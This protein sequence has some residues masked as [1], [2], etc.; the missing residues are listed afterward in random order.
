MAGARDA[1][2]CQAGHAVLRSPAMA[3]SLPAALEIPDS[4]TRAAGPLP[5]SR[6]RC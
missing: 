6:E 2:D 4:R 5:L 3:R 1:T